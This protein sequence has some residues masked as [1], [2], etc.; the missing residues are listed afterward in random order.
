M[1]RT[2]QQNPVEQAE[3]AA[4]LPADAGADLTE[5]EALYGEY[6][7]PSLSLPGWGF[8][9]LLMALP[10]VALPWLLPALLRNGYDWPSL[11][12]L[13]VAVPVTALLGLAFGI[14][15]VRRED[16]GASALVGLGLNVVLVLMVG[17]I[18]VAR[19]F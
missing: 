1:L 9:S 18:I 8:A 4:P 10:G 3:S 15:A 12:P 13:L 7:S 2:G 5:D 17:A 19:Y 6:A 16:G 14:V 11:R